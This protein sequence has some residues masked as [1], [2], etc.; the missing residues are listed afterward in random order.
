MF[1]LK[2]VAFSILN[3]SIFSFLHYVKARGKISFRINKRNLGKDFGGVD[4]FG[5]KSWSW[6]ISATEQ[7]GLNAEGTQQQEG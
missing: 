6:F 2:I 1:R 3:V 5:E 7:R 4:K